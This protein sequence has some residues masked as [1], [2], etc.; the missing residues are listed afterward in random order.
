MF[1]SLND[2]SSTLS[3]EQSHVNYQ[4]RNLLRGFLYTSHA[5]YPLGFVGTLTEQYVW[6]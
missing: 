1:S 2:D 4:N 5:Q 6:K 3:L